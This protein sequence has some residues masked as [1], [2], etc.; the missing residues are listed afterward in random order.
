MI[1]A[2]SSRSNTANACCPMIQFLSYGAFGFIGCIYVS[3]AAL[4][5]F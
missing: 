4:D 1:N 5:Y 2:H 3:L